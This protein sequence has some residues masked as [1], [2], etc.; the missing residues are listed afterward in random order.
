MSRVFAGLLALLAAMMLVTAFIR[1][2]LGADAAVGSVYG[3]DYVRFFRP[4]FLA[5]DA[6]AVAGFYNPPWMLVLVGSFEVF[7]DQRLAVWVTA[8]LCAFVWVCVRLKMP[9]WCV[10]P[11]VVFSGAL[12]GVFVGNVEGLTALGLVLPAPLGM[13]LLMLKPQ[14]GLAVMAFHVVD[15][16]VHEGWRRAVLIVLPVLVLFAVSVALYGGWFLKP[17]DLVGREWNTINYF[18]MGV[19]L[20]AALVVAGVARRNVGYALMA[21]PFTAPYMIFHT[22]AF[23]YLGVVL[24]LTREFAILREAFVV[25]SLKAVEE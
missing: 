21:V 17:L 24:V 13:V 7:G 8:N 12:M 4:A 18:P 20:G 25:R 22:W 2:E 16:C 10:L 1:L 3:V 19:P 9:L 14:I 15:A 6:Y 5:D 11:F 23:P